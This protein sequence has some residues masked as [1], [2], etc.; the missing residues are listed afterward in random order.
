MAKNRIILILVILVLIFAA[1]FY[2]FFFKKEKIEFRGETFTTGEGVITQTLSLS[3]DISGVDTENNFLM[4]KLIDGNEKIKVIVSDTTKFI[5]LEAPFS[6]ENPPPAGTQF[7][8]E[9]KEITI[10]D[11]KE[12]DEV[13]V[14]SKDDVS[15][16]SEIDNVELVQILP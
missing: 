12:G 9:K 2:F 8:P 7:V 11:F 16:K 14:I 15:G 4:V 5:K 3:G 10:S 6:S 13:L 1:I